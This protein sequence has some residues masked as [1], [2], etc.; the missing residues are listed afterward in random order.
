M[1][2]FQDFKRLRCECCTFGNE[3]ALFVVDVAEQYN[4]SVTLIFVRR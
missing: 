2:C 3:N 4:A 1:K